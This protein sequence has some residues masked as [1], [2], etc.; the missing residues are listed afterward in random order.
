MR[1]IERLIRDELAA[2]I[3]LPER[4][5]YHDDHAELLRMLETEQWIE[6]TKW[7]PAYEVFGDYG[8]TSELGQFV[9]EFRLWSQEVSEIR[10]Q[11]FYDHMA[12][13]LPDDHLSVFGCTSAL[14]LQLEP[15]LNRC[16]RIIR[17]IDELHAKTEQGEPAESVKAKSE[18]T[19]KAEIALTPNEIAFLM[20]AKKLGASKEIMAAANIEAEAFGKGSSQ[21]RRVRDS[22]RA[23]GLIRT[24]PGRGTA[25]TQ[26]GIEYLARRA[27]V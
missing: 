5:Y 17:R 6:G 11:W 3:E 13:E 21:N 14:S 23:K 9:D 8:L 27:E 22:L 24:E 18:A 10:G 20:A 4:S 1:S 12:D 7:K 2:F 19:P 16:R 15:M 25:L 26:S